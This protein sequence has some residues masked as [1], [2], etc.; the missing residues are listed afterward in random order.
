MNIPLNS[1]KKDEDEDDHDEDDAPD[2]SPL[3]LQ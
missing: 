1:K 3:L 2:V